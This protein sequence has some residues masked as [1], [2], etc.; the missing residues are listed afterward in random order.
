MVLL[1]KLETG[2]D[3][4]SVKMDHCEFYVHMKGLPLPFCHGRIAVHIGNSMGKFI[5]FDEEDHKHNWGAILRVRVSIDITQPL[6]RVMNIE[7]PN[8]QSLQVTFSY[9]RLP[10]FCYYC[11]ML[12]HLVKDCRSCL[13]LIG[14]R[15]R[16]DDAHLAYGEW[17][18]ATNLSKFFGG[19][20]L[21]KSFVIPRALFGIRPSTSASSST[22]GILGSPSLRRSGDGIN[23]GRNNGSIPPSVSILGEDCAPAALN[24]EKPLQKDNGKGKEKLIE[25]QTCVNAGSSVTT[26]S[27]NQIVLFQSTK[28]PILDLEMSEAHFNSFL[29]PT[30]NWPKLPSPCL[31]I[32]NFQ[33]SNSKP[34]HKNR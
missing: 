17:L 10:N 22:Q 3:P 34:N 23:F 1:R 26:A 11:G 30:P 24:L 18:R 28:T 27:P 2:E 16:I 9:E 4:G 33:Q 12:G 7:G 8:N 32:P 6:Q 20:P 13:H 29:P 15:D 31:T 25:N 19:K 5:D 14:A 21:S